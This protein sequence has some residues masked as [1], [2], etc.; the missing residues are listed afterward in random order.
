[1][2]RDED[3][4]QTSF[5]T[6]FTVGLFAGATGYFLFATKQ[7]AQLRRQLLKDWEDAK[8]HLVKEGVIEHENIS[9]RGF[10]KDLVNQATTQV[11]ELEHRITAEETG[12]GRKTVKPAARKRETGKRFKGV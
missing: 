9:F 11:G 1:M 2:P 12:R 5:M 4:E 3:T 8:Q 10:L 7:G 6:G